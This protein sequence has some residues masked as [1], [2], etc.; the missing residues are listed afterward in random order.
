VRID[1]TAPSLTVADVTVPATTLG[2]ASVPSYTVSVAD[3]LDP[4]PAVVCRPLAPHQLPI[5]PPGAAAT[6]GC[7]ATDR[8]G[9]AASRSFRIHVA[10]AA[11]QIVALRA[12]LARMA[13]SPR[14]ARRLDRDLAKALHA[15]EHTNARRACAHL[16]TFPRHVDRYRH[17]GTLTAVQAAQLTADASRI[18]SVVGCR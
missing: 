12:L 16:G 18:A 15:L 7:T 11:E 14:I 6:V 10:G 1:L 3:N 13:P 4:S 2:G 8:A 5:H 17:D 9:N